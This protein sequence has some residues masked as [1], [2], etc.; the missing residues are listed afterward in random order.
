M[1]TRS[2]SYPRPKGLKL[3][4][5]TEYVRTNIPRLTTDM[6]VHVRR[7]HHNIVPSY[8]HTVISNSTAP[9]LLTPI[10]RLP[11]L[12]ELVV[13]TVELPPPSLGGKSPIPVPQSLSVAPTVNSSTVSFPL[14]K[15]S[16]W[17]IQ[18]RVYDWPFSVAL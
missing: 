10:P 3:F 5:S 16:P 8:H 11:L 9:S 15:N 7:V 12:F 17:E 14:P 2:P 13:V 18:L 1:R 6:Y 4:S